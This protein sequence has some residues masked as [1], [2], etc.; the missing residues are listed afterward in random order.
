MVNPW[1]EYDGYFLNSIQESSL[2][3]SI[4]SGSPWLYAQKHGSIV[5][6]QEEVLYTIGVIHVQ[7]LP[8]FEG[9]QFALFGR[10]LLRL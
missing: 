4:K 6:L 10:L 9:P 2:L 3:W 8:L 1:N 5:G 7:A